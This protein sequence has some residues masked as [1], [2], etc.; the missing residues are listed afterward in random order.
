MGFFRV[1]FEPMDRDAVNARLL[2]LVL[3]FFLIVFVL[4]MLR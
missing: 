1:K 4:G 3:V 2:A